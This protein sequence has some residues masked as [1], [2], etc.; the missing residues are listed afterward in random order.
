MLLPSD[1][2]SRKR[3][4]VSENA[5]P[6]EFAKSVKLRLHSLLLGI[7]RMM[8]LS[9]INTEKDPLIKRSAKQR[10]LAPSNWRFCHYWLQAAENL[11]LVIMSVSS[12]KLLQFKH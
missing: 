9:K 10:E 6:L 12:L 1:A 7:R 11:L 5:R 2:R 8:C 3:V 4:D